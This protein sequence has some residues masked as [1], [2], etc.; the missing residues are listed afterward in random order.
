LSGGTRRPAPSG[1]GAD[2]HDPARALGWIARVLENEQ[3][4]WQVTGGL[5]ARVYG[6]LRPLADIDIW[7]A[8]DGAER[9]LPHCASRDLVGP[10]HHRDGLWD[11][12]FCRL[13]YSGQAIEL[14][15]ADDARYRD[16]MAG[17]WRPAGVDFAASVRRDVLGVTIPLVPRAHLVEMKRRLARSVDLADLA[18][19][20]C[21]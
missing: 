7:I 3:V 5:A 19:M 2:S 1:E 8:R 9:V 16:R 14:G 17:V 18:G 20:G 6:S 10:A 13:L 15:I 11:L 21:P 4:S 12:T